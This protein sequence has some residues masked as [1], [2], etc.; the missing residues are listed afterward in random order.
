MMTSG[1]LR[2]FGSARISRASSRPFMPGMSRSVMTNSASRRMIGSGTPKSQS[3]TP[4][5][6]PWPSPFDVAELNVTP[7]T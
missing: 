5:P 1:T 2:I 7:Q 3:N 4:R 6:I